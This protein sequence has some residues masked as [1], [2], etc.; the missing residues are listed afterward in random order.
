MIPKIFVFLKGD[1]TL[2]IDSSKKPS[3][4]R[5]NQLFNLSLDVNQLIFEDYPKNKSFE[6]DL[7]EKLNNV[8]QF[9]DYIQKMQPM[10]LFGKLK[11]V[12]VITLISFLDFRDKSELSEI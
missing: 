1:K 7:P 6:T 5:I 11:N 2:I 8:I 9:W 3:S 12:C 4:E 10:S